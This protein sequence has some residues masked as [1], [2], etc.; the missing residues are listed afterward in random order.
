MVQHAILAGLH[1]I[2]ITEDLRKNVD[3]K[4]D[5]VARCHVGVVMGASA[6]SM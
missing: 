5:V 4:T 3:V 1:I 6:K 2:L